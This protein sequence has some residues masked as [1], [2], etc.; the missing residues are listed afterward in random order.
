MNPPPTETASPTLDPILLAVMVRA[1][2]DAIP[3]HPAAQA[4]EIEA[5]RQAAFTMM[6]MLRPRDLLEAM[7]AARI[8]A[9]EFQIMDAMRGAAQPDLP[10]N[11]KARMRASAS[12][13][14]R[15]HDAAR[16]ELTRRQA[17]PAAK[18]AAL[19]MAVPAPRPKPA[20]AP[21]AA[22]RP[23]AAVAPRRAAGGFVP[24]T[25]AEI[26]QLVAGL[27]ASE[28]ARLAAERGGAPA[29]LP[30]G[31]D[32]T[33][34]TDALL[35]GAVATARAALEEIGAPQADLGERLQAEVAA[36]AAASA[37]K[38]AA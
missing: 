2:L 19:P 24:P 20:P 28:D 22:A 21:A 10:P 37:T 23:P 16:A 17:Y 32:D 27:M 3:H 36:R 35:E 25:E 13:M 31:D 38:L 7:L 11:L 1:A 6:G 26:E 33:A 30:E 8:V 15:M 12:A 4:D 34:A 18:P 29:P 5:D 9:T 14:T